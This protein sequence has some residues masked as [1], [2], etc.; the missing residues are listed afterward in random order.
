[1]HLASFVFGDSEKRMK[2]LPQF[3]QRKET[4]TIKVGV[5]LGQQR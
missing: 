4:K 3:K 2:T 5:V 1:M